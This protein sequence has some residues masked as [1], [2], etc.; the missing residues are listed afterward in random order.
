MTGQNEAF[1]SHDLAVLGKLVADSWGSVVDLDWSVPAGTLEWSC[2]Y[3]ADHTVDCVFS[4]ALFLSSGAQDHYPA[5][6]ELHALPD[7]KPSDLVEGLRAV[8]TMLVA[9]IDA[10]PPGTHAIVR[11]RPAPA[12]GGPGEFAARGAL[13]MVLHGHDVCVGL[14]V[15]LRPPNDMCERLREHTRSWPIGTDIAPTD[16]AWSDLLQRSG[17][18]RLP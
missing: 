17:R 9:V 18:A 6:G 12:T 16:D 4:Y 15:S 7:A 11:L 10:A 13:E 8:T 3:T 5:F 1:T 14:G 2:W